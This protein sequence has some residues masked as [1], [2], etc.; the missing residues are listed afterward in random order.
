MGI[1][2]YPQQPYGEDEGAEAEGVETVPR[3]EIDSGEE[4]VEE[5]AA[6]EDEDVSSEDNDSDEDY[7]IG[8]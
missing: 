1:P 4:G 3:D 7:A 2:E 6:G 8:R 5:A